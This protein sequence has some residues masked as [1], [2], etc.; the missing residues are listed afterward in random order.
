MTK[1]YS[2]AQAA[3]RLGITLDAVYRLLYAG[4]LP[5][6]KV[7]TRWLLPHASVEGRLRAKKERDESAGR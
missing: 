5:A 6:T 2:P 3:R 7:D 4:K 1:A